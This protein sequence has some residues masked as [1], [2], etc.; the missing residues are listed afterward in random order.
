MV[1]V[2]GASAPTHFVD[3]TEYLERGIASLE[4]HARY[5]QH[6]GTNAREFLTSSAE[7]AGAE[8]GVQYATAFELIPF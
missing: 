6:V 5:L 3:V 8:A 2:S 1:L 7:H 4:A